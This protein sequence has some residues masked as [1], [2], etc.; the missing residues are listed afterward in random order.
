M[1]LGPTRASYSAR[2]WPPS[3]I[4]RWA[5]ALVLVRLG[6]KCSIERLE[7]AA[8]RAVHIGAYSFASVVSILQHRLE[9][10]PLPE[11]A[12]VSPPLVIHDNIRGAVYYDTAVQ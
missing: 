10:Q 11:A 8:A 7:A 6:S 4:R 3:R 2:F 5:I 1:P 9:N 12:T